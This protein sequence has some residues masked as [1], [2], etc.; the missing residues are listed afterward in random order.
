MTSVSTDMAPSETKSKVTRATP[1]SSRSI[2]S[3]QPARLCYVDDSR[4]SAYVVKRMLR[5]YG[6]IVDHFDSAEPALIALVNEHYDLLLTDLKVSPKGM[7]GDDLVRALR[8][9]GREEICQ[10][11]I[12]VITGSTDRTI[13]NEVYQAGANQILTKPVN[14][15]ELSTQIKKLVSEKPRRRVEPK[16]SVSGPG[17]R[18]ASSA[19][20]TVVQFG[21]EGKASDT[22]PH[23]AQ[24]AAIVGKKI[25]KNIGTK[26]GT[27]FDV[28]E[29]LS[30][31]DAIPVLN[32]AEP[33]A[34]NR[35]NIHRDIKSHEVVDA[36]FAADDTA[37]SGL[38][39]ETS[40][41]AKAP[42][43]STS[44]HEYESVPFK[45]PPQSMSTR[46]ILS[47]GPASNKYIPQPKVPNIPAATVKPTL[48]AK[49]GALLNEVPRDA[50]MAARQE[51]ARRAKVAILAAQ[52]KQAIDS[53]I[54]KADLDKPN[55]EAAEALKK[56]KAVAVRKAM[57]A[58]K[59]KAIDAAN[60]AQEANKERAADEAQATATSTSAATKGKRQSSEIHTEYLSLEPLE[61]ESINPFGSNRKTEFFRD[62][63]GMHADPVSRSTTE[64]NPAAE[65]TAVQPP[66]QLKHPQDGG[67]VE[68]PSPERSRHP[69]DLP[70]GTSPSQQMSQGIN[71]MQEIERFPL[72]EADLTD[73]FASSRAM[74]ALTSVFELY[75]LKKILFMA[76]LIVA[77]FFSWGTWSEMF[78]DGVQVEL[79]VVEQGEIFQAM[80]Y[81]GKVVSKHKVD[82]VPAIAGRLTEI[83]VD[84]GDTVKTGDVLARLDDREAKSFLAKASASLNSAK[85][86]VLL[87]ERTLERLSQAFAKGAVARQLVED[88]EVDLRSA[89]ARESIAQEEESSA[90][91]GLENPRIVAA[92]SGVVTARLV[93]VG[94]WVVPSETLF[95]LIDPK[96]REIEVKV[97][98]SDSGGIAVG[99]TVSLSSDAFPGLEW[100]ESV[101][102]LAAATSSV[103]NA[104]TVS[105]YISLGASAPS[106]RFGQQVDADIRTAWNPNAIKVP[107]GSLLAKDGQ[108][109]VAVLEE[110]KARLV[111]VTTGIEDFSHVEITQG[112]SVGE[113]IILANGK[114][115]R[116]GER[117]RVASN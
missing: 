68:R 13:L 114:R 1:E 19:G 83:L 55:L 30:E 59:Q 41:E 92:F 75:G 56:L 20:A 69:N 65:P 115:L 71:V 112:L 82:I 57:L 50:T 17:A 2:A 79:A 117:V 45:E 4:T 35:H 102:R 116:D 88:A 62:R 113:T 46:R 86:D 78:D 84:E 23:V 58:K 34:T 7:D 111:E 85:E 105:V 22:Y 9:S 74:S 54:V 5:P 70:K 96:Q 98:A 107:F 80:N 33:L 73:N 64:L 76:A 95:T 10:L 103:G 91:H 72:V 49:P 24:E 67:K 44:S 18:T 40:L 51:A 37:D 93:E 42:A 61:N 53:R 87:A 29:A 52:R 32:L 39:G 104:N 28:D 97:D 11:P 38:F 21:G 47:H 6:Y 89:K 27:D 3:E 36:E 8:N 94:Q 31:V 60:A 14:G 110:G 66:P 43:E 26:V 90:I 12:I 81:P 108:T 63:S 109:W 25:G 100:S 106:L 99:Q 16:E 101:T 48:A 77:A 15:E